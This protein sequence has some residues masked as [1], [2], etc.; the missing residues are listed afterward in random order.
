[1]EFEALECERGGGWLYLSDELILG[2]LTD[3]TGKDAIAHFYSRRLLKSAEFIENRDFKKITKDDELVRIDQMVD[4]S[5]LV[6]RKHNKKYYA[7][8]GSC[9]KKLRLQRKHRIKTPKTE[10]SESTISDRLAKELKGNR[11]VFIDESKQRIDV[12][13]K[14][15]I[16]E[17]KRYRYRCAAIGQVSYYGEFYPKKS[18]RIHLFQCESNRDE[19][20]E[21]LC[22]RFNIVVTYED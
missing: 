6:S 20:F 15:T 13:T 11:E 17:V 4:S 8:T 21:K 12:M 1:M 10:V 16:I 14:T 19:I 9:L 3:E 2:E 22:E 5:I 18:L 7:I